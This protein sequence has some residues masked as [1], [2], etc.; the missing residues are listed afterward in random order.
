MLHK[1][2]AM[3]DIKT[4][5]YWWATGEEY[6]K[7]Q[8]EVYTFT[9]WSDLGI[10]EGE[11]KFIYHILSKHKKK[12]CVLDSRVCNIDLKIAKD[13]IIRS[14]KEY[15][16]AHYK[17]VWMPKQNRYCKGCQLYKDNMCELYNSFLIPKT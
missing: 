13:I 8:K 11:K 9:Y 6:G 1:D 14:V 15:I 10:E 16:V 3:W 17:N 7:L 5:E 2:G 4:A 12:P